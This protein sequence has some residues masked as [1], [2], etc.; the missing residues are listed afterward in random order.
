M[1][2]KT[3]VKSPDAE[4]HLRVLLLVIAA[5]P[6]ELKE[7]R[8]REEVVLVVLVALIVLAEDTLFLAFPLPPLPITTWL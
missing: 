6:L 4:D 2:S 1:I 7:P 3:E 8:K 5:V